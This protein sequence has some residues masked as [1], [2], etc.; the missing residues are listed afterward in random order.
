[1]CITWQ[2]SSSFEAWWSFQS[3]PTKYVLFFKVDFVK[4]FNETCTPHL[5]WI[6]TYFFLLFFIPNILFWKV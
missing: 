5:L 1:M 4:K 3:I 6:D 2:F